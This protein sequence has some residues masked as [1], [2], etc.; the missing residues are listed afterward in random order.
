[1]TKQK[2]PSGPPMTLGNMRRLDVRMTQAVRLAA[3]AAT[4][5][6]VVSAS[7]FERS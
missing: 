2:Q 3:P 6:G 5:H 4:D 1:M 7:C